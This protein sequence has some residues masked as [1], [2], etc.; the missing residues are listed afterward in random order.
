MSTSDAQSR[1]LSVAAR[2]F[3]E[4]GFHAVSVRDIAT[5]AEVSVS[6]VLY[7]GGSKQGLLERIVAEA[8]SQSELDG[9][10]HLLDVNAVH[11]R[12]ELL[13]AYEAFI[14][15]LLAHAI[16][17]PESRRLWMRL[18][19]DQPELFTELDQRYSWPVFAG[20]FRA[21]TTMSE[22]G[23]IQ[24]QPEDLRIFIAGLDW[25]FDGF[26]AAGLLDADGRRSPSTSEEARAAFR[27]HLLRYGKALLFCDHRGL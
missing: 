19:L 12:A 5:A 24:A 6:T 25:M 1:V 7:H 27:S 15:A 18:L 13:V 16:A 22:R 20:V 17:F 23:V 8:F 10:E 21:L 26:F 14:D 4:R 11:S 2:L 3:A 9:F